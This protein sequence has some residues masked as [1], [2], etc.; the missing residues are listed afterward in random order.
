MQYTQDKKNGKKGMEQKENCWNK[1]ILKQIF[2]PEIG[3]STNSIYAG[4][5]WAKRNK[6]A[7]DFKFLIRQILGPCKPFDFAIDI[8]F[9]PVL[10]KGAKARDTG[11]YSY[12]C[13]LIEDGL[14]HAGLLSDDGP[15]YVGRWIIN[16]CQKDGK[17]QTGI[18]VNIYKSS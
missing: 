9:T 12:T 13:K 14:V 2:I 6:L 8:E 15:K 7:S 5:H 1:P 3:P 17:N 18:L 10:G 11:N 4:V 16:P